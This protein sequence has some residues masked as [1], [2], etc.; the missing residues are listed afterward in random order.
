MKYIDVS[1]QTDDLLNRQIYNNFY[2]GTGIHDW[3]WF[4]WAVVRQE[5]LR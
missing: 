1:Y 3:S 2:L 5:L 4:Y